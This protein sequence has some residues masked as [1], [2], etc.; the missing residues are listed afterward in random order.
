MESIVSLSFPLDVED[1]WPPVAVESLP[2][3]VA[4]EGYV[5]QV[6]PLFVKG[7]S[8]GD[9]IGATLEAGSYKVIGWK[10]VVKS[11]RST[12]WLL[13]MRQSETIS[14]V[15]AE[16]RELG[17][18]TV[19]LEDLGVYSV[20]VPESVRIEAVDTALAHLDSDSVAVAFPSLRHEQD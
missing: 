2:F 18:N 17:C 4:P 20:E 1:D 7:L 9:V 19:G 13:R 12:V 11:G 3:R 6:P 16:L 14:A 10:H 5:A 15:L 8:V